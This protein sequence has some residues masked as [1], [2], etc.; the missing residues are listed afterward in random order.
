MISIRYFAIAFINNEGKHL[1]MK[2]SGRSEIATNMWAPV[3]GHLEEGEHK[4]PYEACLREILEETGIAGKHINSLDMKYI[5][6]PNEAYGF[7]NNA[8]GSFGL[9]SPG[10]KTAKFAVPQLE[11]QRILLYQPPI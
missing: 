3:G 8:R 7:S 2:R 1:M 6:I 5:V 9:G 11:P 10:F 4:N